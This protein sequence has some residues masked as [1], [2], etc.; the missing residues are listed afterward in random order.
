[1]ITTTAVV[2][3]GRDK[4]SMKLATT[5]MERNS[6]LVEAAGER[7]VLRGIMTSSKVEAGDRGIEVTGMI[8]GDVY[9]CWWCEGD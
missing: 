3:R 1:M 9:W 5:G 4:R 8:C 2:G 7:I 6:I